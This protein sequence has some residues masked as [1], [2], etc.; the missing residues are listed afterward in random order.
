MFKKILIANRGEIAVRVIR[1]CRELG[2]SPVAI[3]SDVDRASLAVQLADEAY[4]VGDPTPASSYLDMEKVLGAAKDSGCEAIHPGYG[5]LSENPLF[6]QRCEEGGIVF[7]GPSAATLR[8]AGD[9]VAARRAMRKAGVPVIPGTDSPVEDLPELFRVAGKIGFP[10]M[11]KAAGG[12][13]GKGIRTVREK[14]ELES[15]FHLA[16]SE[17]AKAFGDGRLY[18][19]KRLDGARHVEVQVLGDS[20]GKV[21]HLGERDCSL[22][23]RHQKILEETPCSVLT[24]SVRRRLLS[25]AIRGARA[26][27]YSNAGTMEF[28]LSPDHKTFHFLEV[29]ARLQVEHPV[30]EAVTGIDLVREQIRIAAGQGLS[31]DQKGIK[32]RGAAV[33]ARIYAEDPERDFA[34]APGTVG[35]WVLPGGPWIRVDTAASSGSEIPLQYD[36]LIAKVTAWGS[37][38]AEATGRLRAALG[39]FGVTG[40]PTTA[41]FL[42]EILGQEWF[43]QGKYDTGFLDAYMKGRGKNGEGAPAAALAAALI[44]HLDGKGKAGKALS[45]NGPAQSPWVFWG[46]VRQLRNWRNR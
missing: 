15:A 29:N 11:L 14:A 5:F 20:T 10:M 19:E 6:A 24:A 1:A 16:S 38:R 17:A 39:E 27:G 43:L 37:D 26:I 2:V 7:I 41:P 25:A 46:R 4:P 9:K 23:R 34:P 13:G 44:H 30:T 18:V 33:E 21:V 36:P 40:V 31:F 8:L 3:F 28:L 12:G 35:T 32:H 22:Q 45:M 42:K